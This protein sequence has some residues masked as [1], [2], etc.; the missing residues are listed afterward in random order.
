M[1]QVVEAEED[2]IEYTRLAIFQRQDA[3]ENWD[4]KSALEQNE[5]RKEV[6]AAWDEIETNA[7]ELIDLLSI[8]IDSNDI[9][10][11]NN[12]NAGLKQRLQSIGV[13]LAKVRAQR[14]RLGDLRQATGS[15]VKATPEHTS[16]MV[17]SLWSLCQKQILPPYSTDH[18]EFRIGSD[19]AITELDTFRPVM[20]DGAMWTARQLGSGG[21]GVAAVFE[22]VK[23]GTPINRVVRKETNPRISFAKFNDPR[24]W[25]GDT[26]LDAFAGGCVPMEYHT[27]KLVSDV[28]G[29]DASNTVKLLAPPQV[30]YDQWKY[31]L[32]MEFAPHGDTDQ[33]LKLHDKHGEPIPE[34]FLWLVFQ[35][36]L[37]NCMIMK[38]GGITEKKDPWSE[39]VYCDMKAENL[40]LGSADTGYYPQYPTP[41]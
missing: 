32:Y 25:Q 3:C 9:Q 2:L 39:I 33:L 40:F 17:G 10:P 4:Q 27:Q 22:Y 24:Y 31:R 16:Q 19:V 6:D 8:H 38:Q 36:L 30:I 20:V 5:S 23:D 29:L 12:L 28:S 37:N 34:L 13:A 11:L 18:S 26:T 15:K 41:K 14:N 35:A 21:Q 1:K 7:Q